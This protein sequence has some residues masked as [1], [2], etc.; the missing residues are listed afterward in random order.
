MSHADLSE[1][2]MMLANSVADFARGVDLKRVRRLSESKAEC[3]RKLWSQMAELGWLGVLVPEDY[4]GMGLKLADM[5]IVAQGLARVLLPEPLTAAAVL[6]A[7]V[8]S[9]GSNEALKSKLLEGL[10]S[11]DMLP[12]LAWQE[13]AGT[14]DTGNVSAQATPF[15]GGF[16]VNGT[17][18]F[19]I[20]ASHADGYI[21]SADSA[22][23]MQL[24]WVPKNTA[25]ATIG[26]DML[27]DGR[28]AGT[29]NL[30]DVTV[31]KDNVLNSGAAATNS[32]ACAL[33]HAAAIASAEL[34]G[35]MGRSLE[36]TLDYLKTRVQFG[37][38][39]GSF[40]AL[41][42]RAVDLYIQQELSGAVLNDVL[43]VLD[44]EPDA[45]TRSAAASRAKA[46]CTDA[47]LLIT[48]QSIQMH[49]AIGFTEDCDVGLYVKRAMTL[50]AWLGNGTAH[51]RRYAKTEILEGAA[52]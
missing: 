47:A 30:K 16:R 7:R 24:L 28:Q 3:D 34:T 4:G 18:K 36:I 33:D 9:D 8:I 17:K 1:H 12:A 31:S 51:R 27:A 41:Q 2:R 50:A 37:K 45:K 11:G 6:A 38:A 10:V 26:F 29:L 40:Q 32:V 13:A 20:G 39:I 19:V 23:G 35:I 15:E 49:G 21:V 22:R 46:R 5:A 25:G 52:V 42:H 43:T 14:L 48:R 44:E